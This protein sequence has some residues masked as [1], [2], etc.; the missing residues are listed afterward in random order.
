MFNVF[1]AAVFILLYYIEVY[2]HVPLVMALLNSFQ[3][4]LVHQAAWVF[5]LFNL[6]SAIFFIAIN[7]PL[8]N[9]LARSLPPSEEEGLSQPKYLSEF[10][11]EDPDTGLELIRLEQAREL[12][13]IAAF[14]STARDDYDGADLIS[15]YEA[16][17]SLSRQVAA[18]TTEVAAMQMHSQTAKDHAYFQTRQALLDQLADSTVAGVKIIMQ[19]KAYP[20]LAGLSDACMESIDFLLNLAA[21]TAQTNTPEEVRTLLD[22]SSSNGPSME[23]LRKAYMDN[24][25]LDL[26]NIKRSLL[27]LTMMTERVV[28]FLNRLASL[29]PPRTE[30]PS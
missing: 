24:D 16:F 26:A 15:R 19:T 1:G 11:P 20:L 6:T 4:D 3:L 21:E 10:R 22:L 12:E 14:V 30:K 2:G 18:S 17:K 25:K 7:E 9:W 5:L 8:A 29:M 28:W 23:K 27:D 13:Q